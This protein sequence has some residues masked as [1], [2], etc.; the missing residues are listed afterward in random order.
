[1][2]KG[3]KGT[4]ENQE[5]AAASICQQ[6]LTLI[7]RDYRLVISHGNG[8]QVGNL[9]LLNETGDES[10]PKMPLDVL[11][12]QTEGSLGYFLQQAMLNELRQRSISKYVVTVVTQV[13]VD[14]K[15][16]AFDKPTKPIGPFLSKKEA[17]KR[18][19]ELNW[20]IVEDV[21]RGWRR[22]VPSPKPTK[23]VQRHM[24]RE[25]AEAGHIVIAAGGGG[26]PIIK[27][28]DGRYEGTEAVI[29]KDLTSSILA[30]QIGAEILIILTGVPYIYTGFAG[31]D[32]NEI[33]A[34]TAEQL[35]ELYDEG[36]FP[37]G[38]MGPKVKA[39]IEFL[40][41]G[42]KRAIVTDPDTLPKALL[43]RGGT[44][45]IGGC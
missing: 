6:L 10:V 23:V 8:P 14:P 1:M 35:R 18:R 19:D 25:S 39:V 31:S 44:H 34:I 11:V 9:L 5:R 40:E 15:D 42:G 30:T 3:E 17:E 4:I 41:R 22:V 20:K 16:E 37:A 12:A 26:I 32:Q 24:I 33:S 45:I 29:D 38:S 43:G 21:G 28:P 7:E 2:Q 27:K 36:E 13:L